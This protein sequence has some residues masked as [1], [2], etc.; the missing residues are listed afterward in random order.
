I[1]I[2]LLDANDKWPRLEQSIYDV[3]V[4][5]SAAVMTSL[6]TLDCKDDDESSKQAPVYF[7]LHHSEA[8]HSV[9]FFVLDSTSGELI[10][11]KPLDRE[12]SVKHQLTVSCRDRGRTEHADFTRINIHVTDDNDHRPFFIEETI[13]A[14]INAGASPGSVVTQVQAFDRDTGDNGRLSYSIIK[15]NVGGL[16]YIDETLGTVHISRSLPLNIPSEYQIMIRA[17]DYGSQMYDTSVTVIIEFTSDINEPP[18]WNGINIPSFVEVSEWAAIGSS[19]AN[20]GARSST[21]LTYKITSGNTPYTFM[22]SPS[23]GIVSLVGELDH[24]LCTW[25]NLTITVSNAAGSFTSRWLG[26]RVLDENDWWPQWKKMEYFGIVMDTYDSGSPVF[27]ASMFDTQI[28]PL[29]VKATDEDEGENGRISYSIIEQ[30]AAK[31]FSINVHTGSLQVSGSLKEVSNRTVTFSVWAS[32]AGTPRRYCIAPTGVSIIVQ[33]V[34]KEGPN[35]SQIQYNTTLYL[36]TIEGAKVLCIDPLENEDNEDNTD[37]WIKDGNELNKFDFDPSSMC[38]LVND[39]HNLK[40][41]YNLTVQATS[42]E[43]NATTI[44][45]IQVEDAPKSNIIFSEQSYLINVME[46]STQE[47]NIIS[48]GINHLPL[49]QNVHYEIVNPTDFFEIHITSGMI[50]TTGKPIDYEDGNHHVLM[51]KAFDVNEPQHFGFVMVDVAVIDVNDNTPLFVNQPF[52]ALVTTDAKYG[53]III[54]VQAIDAD[55]G[56][57]G[58][59]RYEITSRNTDIFTVDEMTGEIMVNKTVGVSGETYRLVITAYDGGKPPFSSKAQ[60]HVRVVSAEGPVFSSPTYSITVPE[61]ISVGSAITTIDA[62]AATK[63]SL[64]FSIIQGNMNEEFYLDYNTGLKSSGYRCILRSMSQ[65]DYEAVSQ[66]NLTVRARDP[67]TGL[68]ADSHVELMLS[69]VNDNAP[70]FEEDVYRVQVSEAVHVGY[71]LLKILAH[72]VDTGLGGQVHYFCASSCNLFNIGMED[73]QI[74]LK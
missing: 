45:N 39:I 64:V 1:V 60:V 3:N 9:G 49:N 66:Y 37:F 5:E 42:G 41:E 11:A 27:D 56:M 70:Q 36:P 2:E 4:S 32:D 50:K 21:S 35:F 68:S 67:V 47:V 65:L 14:K 6:L 58:S 19:I 31:Y 24:E 62:Q 17:Q 69:D 16:F 43:N 18:N 28:L 51:I 22:V 34:K 25:Y 61:D 12:V 59:V 54:Q 55:S 53:D 46:N 40:N 33:N 73:G 13:N 29:A 20:M 63:N 23:S 74:T 71:T 15:G 26:V 72:D 7:S 44:L 57:F 52:Y 48:V 30:A 8:V 38:L 10:L